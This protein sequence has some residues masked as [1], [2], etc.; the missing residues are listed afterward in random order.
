MLLNVAFEFLH[1]CDQL[2]WSCTGQAGDI[3]VGP[4]RILQK[5]DEPVV[6]IGPR[7]GGN[8]VTLL[9]RIFNMLV[10]T[11]LPGGEG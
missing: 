6:G 11:A 10:V 4:L 3:T 9:H 8:T 7:S 1:C 2:T 5:R